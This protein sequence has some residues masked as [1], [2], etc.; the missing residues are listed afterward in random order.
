MTAAALAGPRRPGIRLRLNGMA[1]V[2]EAEPGDRTVLDAVLRARPETPYACRVG[3]CGCCRALV[4]AGQVRPTGRQMAL[5]DAEL[6]AGYV[7]ACRVRA[8]GD[9]VELDFDA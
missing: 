1:S 4:T 7:L 5:D 6:A 3:L 2:T 9:H 8:V